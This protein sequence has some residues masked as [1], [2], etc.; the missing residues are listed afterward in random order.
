MCG[1]EIIFIAAPWL[2]PNVPV[3]KIISKINI[4]QLLIPNIS[5]ALPRSCEPKDS[6]D[7]E[8]ELQ[9]KSFMLSLKLQR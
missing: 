5:A 2:T 9:Q 1:W 4:S 7:E 3:Q 6:S 8:S